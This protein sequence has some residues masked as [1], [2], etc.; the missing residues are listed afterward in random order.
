MAHPSWCKDPECGYETYAAH[1]RDSLHLSPAATPS[2][3]LVNRT[4]GQPDEPIQ[5]TR[6]RQ[7]RFDR[8]NSAF[9]QLAEGGV[10]GVNLMDAPRVLKEIGG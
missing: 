8:E 9:R 5:A 1:L 10:N 7:A 3:N 2:R 6:D 4:P